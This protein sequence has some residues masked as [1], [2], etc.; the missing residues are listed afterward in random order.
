MDLVTASSTGEVIMHELGRRVDRS[1]M[2]QHWPFNFDA[3]FDESV[4]NEELFDATACNLVDAVV[5]DNADA[6]MFAYGQ[7]GSGKT[8]SMAGAA[9]LRSLQDADVAEPGMYQL[10]AWRLFD[11]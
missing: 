1:V 3:A 10:T 5:H 11:E 2:L 8:F 9:G 4:S 6:T 7:T